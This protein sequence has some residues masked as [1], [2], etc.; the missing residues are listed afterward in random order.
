MRILPYLLAAVVT[1]LTACSS[2]KA[3]ESQ[4]ASAP[5]EQN[6]SSNMR[7]LMQTLADLLPLVHRREDFQKPENR[8]RILTATQKLESLSHMIGKKGA[9][10]EADPAV[11]FTAEQ[12]AQ[13]LRRTREALQFQQLEYARLSLR[14]V[15]GYCIA[16]HTRHGDGTQFPVQA[17]NS[18]VE[19]LS[20]LE[21]AEFYTATRQF[22]RA[23]REY[24]VVLAESA[25]LSPLEWEHAARQALA[26]EVRV[27]R[28]P[29]GTERVI[30]LIAGS[31]RATR[32]LQEDA[33]QWKQAVT[34]WRAEEQDRARFVKRVPVKQ[35]QW[36]DEMM[37]RARKRQ[38]YEMDRAADV[39]YLR[40]S[41]ALSTVLSHS[42][43]RGKD[44]ALALLLAGESTEALRDLSFWTMHETLYE[45]CILAAPKSPSARK[46][47]SRLEASVLA[48]YTGS[49]GVALPEEVSRKLLGLKKRLSK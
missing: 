5:A 11:R 16:C 28:S 32:S 49:G 25:S 42:E 15:T 1:V 46:C 41:D 3:A 2:R 30:N 13:D 22:D 34:E 8:E 19:K 6:W 43:L 45:Q 48:S 14:N 7:S 12:M 17:F 33:S 47:Y 24:D 37:R 27:K 44:L 18:K 29:E 4:D 38:R 31:P 21:R 39:E 26:L 10:P 23:A 20:P 40:A 36:A 9:G 35:V